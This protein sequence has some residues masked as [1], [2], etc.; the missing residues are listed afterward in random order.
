MT[1]KSSIR[2]KDIRYILN[3][4]GVKARKRYDYD[5]LEKTYLDYLQSN[6]DDSWTIDE[7]KKTFANRNVVVIAPGKTSVEC[8]EWIQKYINEHN[9]LVVTVNFVHDTISCDYI[10][11]S[12]ARRYQYWA[13]DKKFQR[14]NKIVTSNIISEEEK[15]DLS[16]IVSFAQLVKCGWEHLDNSTILLLRLLDKL[17]VANV[18][19]AGLDGYSYNVNGEL[20][21]AAQYLELSNVKENPME[22]NR[23]IQ[24]MLT[25]FVGTKREK[26]EIKF[27]T[28]SRFESVL[29][30]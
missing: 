18:A 14:S 9:A 22:L 26:M 28:P 7:L 12:N 20:N 30:K 8:Q 10:Y 25:D 19:I 21:Y 27:I 2:S 5:L 23:E 15:D 4:I 29:E 6:I 3:K 13:Q 24:E 17:E 16:Y 11:I 1:E